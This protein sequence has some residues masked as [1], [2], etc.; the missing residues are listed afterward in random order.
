M[1]GGRSP[2]LELRSVT[3]RYGQEPA[4]AS[5]VLESF[6]MGVVEGELLCVLGRSG[7][8]KSTLL[9]IAGSLL[10]PNSGEVLLDGAPVDAPDP[11]R[12]MVFQEQD[13]LFPWKT[14]LKNVAFGVTSGV[15]SGAGSGRRPV[16]PRSA[17]R[18]SRQAL[19]EVGLEDSADRFPH[20]L[21]G[22]MRQRVALAR[23]FVGRP[24]LLLMD[25]PFGSVDAPQRRDLQLLLRRL[26][27][28]HG[29]TAVFVTHDVEEALFL[30]SRIIVLGRDG[31]I[32]LE[33]R[34]DNRPAAERRERLHS[35]LEDVSS[36]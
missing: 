11:E 25:E 30:G 14:A 29:G 6:S 35:A 5:P 16:D 26:L 24:R 4:E 21:S 8:G 7:C 2:L 33:E 15:R 18:L 12:V 3:F 32:Q 27:D 9:K 31:T 20:Q 34:A 19:Q 1:T 23:A 28:D 10:A 22:G 17:R 13:Q 36:R